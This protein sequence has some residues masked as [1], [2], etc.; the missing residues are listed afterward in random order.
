M[1]PPMTAGGALRIDGKRGSTGLV[2]NPPAT[3]GEWGGERNGM[4]IRKTRLTMLV[5]EVR[6][7]SRAMGVQRAVALAGRATRGG[8]S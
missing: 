3:Q 6:R 4:P 7:R 5:G 2:H 8:S 1:P